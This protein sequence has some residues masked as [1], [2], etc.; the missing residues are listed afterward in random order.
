MYTHNGDVGL[1]SNV[2]FW[3]VINHF[4]KHLSIFY[5]IAYMK[6]AYATYK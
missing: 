1:Q 2:L 6:Y 4:L 5:R 3:L